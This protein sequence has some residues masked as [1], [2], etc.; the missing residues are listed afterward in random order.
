MTITVEHDLPSNSQTDLERVVR[1]SQSI[2]ADV[3]NACESSRGDPSV[4]PFKLRPSQMTLPENQGA[5]VEHENSENL[6]KNENI[7]VNRKPLKNIFQCIGQHSCEQPSIYYSITERK[8]L[9]AD[10]KVTCDNCDFCT[11]E[12]PLYT[13]INQKHGKPLG[14]LNVCLLLPVLCSKMGISDLLLV[15]ACLNIQDQDKRGMQRKLNTIADQ[16]EEMEKQQL[17]E[18]QKYVELIS[19]LAGR[20]GE[21]DLEFDAAFTSTPQAWCDCATQDFAPVIEKTTAKHLLVDLNIGTKLCS[22]PNCEHTDKTCKKK[23]NKPSRGYFS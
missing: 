2:D 15:L 5:K 14:V 6:E 1:L 7:I 10:I 9:C 19:N 8:G 22:K 18:N 23:I 21:T 20:S 16:E 17:V 11:E 12:M 4:L 3:L 13:S